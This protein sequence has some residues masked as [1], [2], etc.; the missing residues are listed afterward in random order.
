M[1]PAC[2]AHSTRSWF[3]RA[4]RRILA[5]AASR[6]EYRQLFRQLRRTTEGALGAQPFART[7]Q[8]FAVLLAFTTMKFVNW[9]APNIMAPGKIS[10]PLPVPSSASE[11]HMGGHPYFYFVKYEP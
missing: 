7:H 6:S 2:S 5:A 4:S 8:D 1:R 9:H 11:E 10:R 3:A